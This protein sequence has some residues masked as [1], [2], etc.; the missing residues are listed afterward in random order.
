MSPTSKISPVTLLGMQWQGRKAHYGDVRP[1]L[2]LAMVIDIRVLC[3]VIVCVRA[4]NLSE[5]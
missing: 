3:I 5:E 2:R 4:L 1:R